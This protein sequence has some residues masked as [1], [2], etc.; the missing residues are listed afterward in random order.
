MPLN[1]DAGELFIHNITQG[2]IL[3]AIYTLDANGLG[4]LVN[5][6]TTGW[7]VTDRYCQ[8]M[9]LTSTNHANLPTALAAVVGTDNIVMGTPNME[10]P[11]VLIINTK[12]IQINFENDDVTIKSFSPIV[13]MIGVSI[14]LRTLISTGV[15]I[16]DV[17]FNQGLPLTVSTHTITIRR[18]AMLDA[19]VAGSL[20]AHLIIGSSADPGTTILSESCFILG[21]DFQAV[22]NQTTNGIMTMRFCLNVGGQISFRVQSTDVYN[23]CVAIPVT[24]GWLGTP[25]AASNHNLST[26]GTAP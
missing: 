10:D 7:L 20:G 26:D 3:A 17:I 2:I 4:I 19:G 16:E 18:C 24:T 14:Q 15:V 13:K 8:V 6:D 12:F 22:F 21:G 1:V 5:V 9:S 23:G 25:D 11:A